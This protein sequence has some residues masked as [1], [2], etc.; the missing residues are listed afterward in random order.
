[1]NQSRFGENQKPLFV[2]EGPIEVKAYRSNFRPFDTLRF[3]DR[4]KLMKASK[5]LLEVGTL[6]AAGRSAT[7]VAEIR[8]GMVTGLSLRGC[9]NCPPGPKA[10]KA[11]LKRIFPQ[12]AEKTLQVPGRTVTLPIPIKR[13]GSLIR[14]VI[15]PIV[16]VI[17]TDPQFCIMVEVG[18]GFCIVCFFDEFVCDTFPD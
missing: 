15:G 12:V 18:N 10:D 4:D 16:I 9:A 8:K 14:I 13:T 7:L 1:M 2:I 11:K 6:E 3:I 17:Q 5:V